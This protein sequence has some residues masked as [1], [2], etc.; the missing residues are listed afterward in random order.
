M[1]LVRVPGCFENAGVVRVPGLPS[2]RPRN[3]E[4]IEPPVFVG[5]RSS[6]QASLCSSF[7]FTHSFSP[8]LQRSPFWKI[9]YFCPSGPGDLSH[10]QPSFRVHRLY[11]SSTNTEGK[12]L[13]RLH[14]SRYPSYSQ[15]QC[16]VVLPP[17]L[18]VSA[19]PDPFHEAHPNS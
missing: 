4:S 12:M 2:R 8:F 10:E 18:F 11:P 5:F 19:P 1:Y 7:F 6:H 14:F 16:L 13:I 9:R 3:S 15:S 17:V